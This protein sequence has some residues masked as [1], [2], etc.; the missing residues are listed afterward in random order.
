M[1]ADGLLGVCESPYP[2]IDPNTLR[3]EIQEGEEMDDTPNE[4]FT[5]PSPDVVDD[6]TYDLPF[7]CMAPVKGRIT[8]PLATGTTPLT[9]KSNSTMGWMWR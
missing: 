9:R 6:N 8:S 2:A 3:F 4:P 7:V 5:I 1:S